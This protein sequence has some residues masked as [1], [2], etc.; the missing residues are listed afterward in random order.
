MQSILTAIFYQPI[1][2]AL[3]WIY[4]II[5]GHDF[6]VAIIILTII[7][8]GILWPFQQAALKSQRAMQ[9]IQP[10]LKALQ[11]QY[12][13]DKGALNKAMVELYAREKVSPFSSC[14]P[15]LIQLP[16]LIGLYQALQ[17]G[18]QTSS[19]SLLYHFVAN[20]GVIN[21]VAFGFLDLSKISIPLAILAGV[22]QFFQTKMLPMSKPS[23]GAGAGSNDERKLAMMNKVMLFMAPAFT[24]YLGFK[25]QGGLTLYWLATTLV[26]ILQQWLFL[27]KHDKAK[28][29]I[30]DNN[31]Q[32]TKKS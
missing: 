20:P 31:V 29:E 26:A 8:R 4:G 7:V 3:F 15:L 22:A 10:K 25:F 1:L 17:N 11:D 12:K 13:D 28:E 32:I 18:L 30:K 24:V 21:P 19:F 6:G 23:S 9:E 27:R 16:F 5:P 14:L 2:N